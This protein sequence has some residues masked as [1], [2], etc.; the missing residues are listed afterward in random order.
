MTGKSRKVAVTGATGL[1][2]SH[3]T[4]ELIGLG[5]TEIVLPVRNAARL[6]NL[7]KT[8]E[9][10]GVSAS[11][12]R[13][14]VIETELTNP[15]ELAEAFEGVDVV[16]N[17]AAAVAL[18]TM[19]DEQLIRSNVD[20]TAHVVDAALAAGVRKLVHVSSIAALGEASEGSPVIDETSLPESLSG[21]PAYYASKCLCEREVARGAACGLQTVT[22]NPA[23]ILGEGDWRSGSTAMIPYLTIG[24]PFYTDGVTAFVDVRD[25]ARAM[26]ALSECEQAAGERFILSSGNLTYREFLTIAA[27]ASGKR[28]PFIRA[29]RA[30]LGL[31]WRGAWLWGKITGKQLLFTR[32]VAQVMVKKTYFSTEKIEKTINFEFTPIE[33]TVDRIIKQY[34][35]EKNG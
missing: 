15:V 25:V 33:T 8:L 35:S 30:A 24:E 3:L 10:M 5:Y 22:V 31:A 11:G 18:G 20:I 23:L 32:D 12:V 2:G 29:G 14:S 27:R 21:L 28:P 9:R 34:L 17:C 26:A 19:D 13:L 6:S 4:A 1:V 16:F 7:D